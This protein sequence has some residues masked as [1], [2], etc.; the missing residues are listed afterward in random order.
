MGRKILVPAKL[1]CIIQRYVTLE[2]P[3]LW[4]RESINRKELIRKGQ[5]HNNMNCT[6][7]ASGECETFK[8]MNKGKQNSYKGKDILK[9]RTH[10]KKMKEKEFDLK[11]Q[12]S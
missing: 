1:S 3:L 2:L 8:R 12:A 10:R 9:N 5:V 4:S 7:E 6:L 11:I